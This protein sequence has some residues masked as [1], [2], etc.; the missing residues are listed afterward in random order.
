MGRIASVTKS[1]GNEKK[2]NA[3][4]KGVPCVST[5]ELNDSSKVG[6]LEEDKVVTLNPS[7]VPSTPLSV[8]L[9]DEKIQKRFYALVNSVIGL[10]CI[11]E[12][13]TVVACC[14]VEPSIVDVEDMSVDAVGFKVDE[15]MEAVVIV[16]NESVEIVVGVGEVGT[17]SSV[18]V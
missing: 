7:V 6:L 10:E 16:V 9:L 18:V 3:K 5:V 1:E 2:G 13:C 15:N 17:A 12:S 14:T 11:D 4:K 8:V